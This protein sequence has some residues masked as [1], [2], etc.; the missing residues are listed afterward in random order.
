MKEFSNDGKYIFINVPYAEAYIPYDIFDK[1]TED[2]SPSS[3]AYNTGDSII[4]IGVFYMRFFDSEE[5]PRDKVK[6]RTLNYPNIIET[7]PSG[8]I[9]VETLDINGDT[10]K[11]KVLRYYMGDILM[12]AET[13]QSATNCE[14]F[15]KLIMSGKVPKSL[16]YDN[17]YFAWRRN[18]DINGV[19]PSVPDITLQTIISEMCRDQNDLSKQFRLTAGKQK[20]DPFSYQM[21]N[22]NAVSAYSSVMT[23]MSFERFAEKLTTSLN[24]TKDGVKQKPSPIEQVITM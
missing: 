5:T 1:P 8:N 9:T 20:T 21:L 16:S 13:K 18:F 4:T 11:Y 24:M 2:P 23:S 19:N 7:R 3:I 10:D 12:D 22:M 17:I 14:M 6:V 15:I